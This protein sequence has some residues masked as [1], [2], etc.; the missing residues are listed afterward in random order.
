MPKW[1]RYR[2]QHKTPP[3]GWLRGNHQPTAVDYAAVFPVNDID[4]AALASPPGAELA[5]P[6]RQVDNTLST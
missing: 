2:R 4:W 6:V 3:R 5:T 1:L